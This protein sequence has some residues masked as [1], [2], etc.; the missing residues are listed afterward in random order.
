MFTNLELQSLV[1]EIRQDPS[2]AAY[3]V[4]DTDKKEDPLAAEHSEIV[5]KHFNKLF[6][7]ILM[8]LDN[9]WKLY[10]EIDQTA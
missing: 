9:I 2:E 1:V 5:Y 3:L 6:W 10:N 8:I 4:L 7:V